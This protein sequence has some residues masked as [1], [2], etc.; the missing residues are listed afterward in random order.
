MTINLFYL[1]RMLALRV[2]KLFQEA[3]SSVPYYSSTALL[4]QRR[5]Q[6]IQIWKLQNKIKEP[7]AVPS[8]NC[9]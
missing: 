9:W 4:E 5:L 1:L 2:L 8:N 6:N 7:N 3:L